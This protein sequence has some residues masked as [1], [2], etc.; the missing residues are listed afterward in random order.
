MEKTESLMLYICD[1]LKNEETFGSTVFN[2]VLYYIDHISYLDTGK[3][4]SDFNYIKQKNGP[5][6]KPQDFLSL[7]DQLISN[8]SLELKEI[9]YF[10]KIKKV[11]E[12]K[13][14]PD[15]NLFSA[16]EISL[17]DSV[18]DIFRR[19]SGAVA[20]HASHNEI[21]WDIAEER[22]E[23]PLYTYLLS[24]EEVTENDINWGKSVLNVH[25]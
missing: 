3:K 10:G 23:L 2:K 6:P 22:E 24:S 20:S 15:I 18:I 14:K 9:K 11:P 4:I 12:N 17:V 5:T 7:R 25:N 13:I 21:C 8:G 19:V 1:K 16:E